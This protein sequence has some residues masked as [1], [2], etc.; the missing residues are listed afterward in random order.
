MCKSYSGNNYTLDLG[1]I[2]YGEPL[3]NFLFSLENAATASTADQLSGTFSVL[4]ADGFTVTG[5]SLPGPLNAGDSYSGL[6]VV[7]DYSKFGVDTETITFN[8]V[9]SNN[10]GFDTALAPITLTITDDIVAP[11]MVYSYAWGDVHII[12]YSGLTYNFQST[13]EFTLVKSLIPGDSFDIQ[14]RLQ[15]LSASASVSVITQ[16][17]VS[18]GSDT[19]T[20][21]LTRADFVYVDGAPTTV[22]MTDP[23]LHL[24]AGTLTELTPNVFQVNWN[25]GETMTVTDNGVWEN[26]ADGIPASEP[27]QVQGLQGEDDGPTADFQLSD[28]TVLPQPLSYATLY[29]PFA[30]SWRV[31]QGSS[32]FDYVNDQNADSFNVPGFPPNP[33]TLSDLPSSVVSAAAA[34]VAAAGITDPGLAQAAELDL[35]ATGNAD[36]AISAVQ[37]IATRLPTTTIV[38]PTAPPPALPAVSVEANPPGVVEAVNAVTPVTFE[39]YLTTTSTTDTV[40]DCTVV[41]GGTGYLG[42]AAFGGSLPSGTVTVPAGEVTANFTVDVPANALGTMPDAKLEVQISA[43]GG[44]TVFAPEATST[45]ANNTPEPGNLAIPELAEL[46]SVGTLTQNGSAYTLDLGTLTAGAAVPAVQLAILNAA[47]APGDSLTGKF[48]APLGSGFLVTGTALSSVL[49]PGDRYDG[50]KVSTQTTTPGT[51]TETLT[52]TPTDINDSGY[53]QALTP[54]TLKITDT[55]LP[56]ASAGLNTPGTIVFP[57]ARVG[58]VDREM[59]SV[60]NTAAAPAPNL[61]VTTQTG[62]SAIATGSISGLAAGQTDAT[63]IMAGLDTSQA[64]L[65]AGIVQLDPVSDAGGGSTEAL[66]AQQIDLYGGIYRLASASIPTINETVH[67]GDPG[68]V[69]LAVTNADPADGVSENLIAALSSASGDVSVGSAGPTGDIAAGA[70]SS[71]LTLTFS[72][73][74]AASLS[75]SAVVALT[76]DGGVG[77]GAGVVDGL[78]TISI[79]TQTVDANINVNNY[80]NPVIEQT[81][82]AG[83][84]SGSGTSYTLD[85]GNINQNASPVSADLEILNDVSGPADLLSGSFTVTSASVVGLSGFLSF[86]NIGAG[87]AYTAPVVTISP[88]TPGDFSETVTFTPVSSNASY[89]GALPVETLTIEGTVVAGTNGSPPVGGPAIAGTLAGQGTTDQAAI[90]PFSGVSITDTNA[91]PTET[92]TVTPSAPADGVLS[93]PNAGTDGGSVNGTTGVYTVTGTPSQVS[94]ALDGLVF[95]PTIHQV[96]PGQTVTTAFTIGVNDGTAT[97]S[98]SVT[99]VIATALNDP[100]VITIPQGG[101]SVDVSGAAAI[102]PGVTVSDPDVGQTETLTVSLD[103]PADGSFF[104][105]S[106]G[107]DGSSIDGTTGAFI[108]SGTPSAVTSILDALVLTPAGSPPETNATATISVSDGIASAMRSVALT[109]P[110]PQ[111]ACYVRGTRI[112]T[113]AGEVAVEALQIGDL[114]VTLSGAARPIKWI[115]QREYKGSEIAGRVDMLPV[116]IAAGA[117]ADLVPRRALSIS[118]EHA[119]FMEGVLIPA[120]ALVNGTTIAQAAAVERVEY[121]HVELDSHDVILAEGAPS[122]SFVDDASRVKFRNAAEYAALYPAEVPVPAVYCAPLMEHGAEVEAAR[123]RIAARAG[124]PATAAEGLCGYVDSVER[125]RIAGWACELARP[126]EGVELEVLADGAVIA[127]VVANRYR[128]D[129]AE[130]GL[131]R[132]WHGFEVS[133]PGGLSPLARHVIAV[134]RAGDGQELSNSPAV[135]APAAGLDDGLA[136]AVTHAVAE[137]GPGEEERVLSFLAARMEQV[138]QRRASLDLGAAAKRALVY[139][140]PVSEGWAASLAALRARSVKTDCS[141]SSAR[142][143]RSTA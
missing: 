1:Q 124:V 69:A 46:T 65:L 80:A 137:V 38:T 98:D 142:C 77:L 105:P 112:L 97:A 119:M 4:T 27:N 50:L 89:S 110:Q 33:V 99:T 129:L 87:S 93:D 58:A 116:T 73:K 47:M 12:T 82:G 115:G 56:P 107:T 20:F 113:I 23:V 136:E 135:L 24:A 49:L 3:P 54:I 16:T 92:V 104:D 63:D 126:D 57:N 51:H 143:G 37:Q 75:G 11:T 90:D 7:I 36:A 86:G 108:V 114:V 130:A 71:A 74:Q 94:A 29:G 17:A 55:V 117:L 123:R 26:V 125:D 84:L 91:N 35:I 45:I 133:I 95:T 96:T 109:L 2:Q 132:G 101:T 13:G 60:S 102:F 79:G 53:S 19:I 48:S 30:D 64:G 5:A 52:F 134:R 39:A 31:S 66:G 118:P 81:S 25:T 6:N 68:S 127:Q 44:D 131:G 10:T 128:G 43:P 83:T 88:T 140:Q 141:T 15:P 32:L 70:S 78:G 61:D 62:A 21:D 138:V 120:R 121:F 67:V 28:G 8:P 85:F 76:S 100:P 122:E 40:V 18:V 22:S 111:V 59:V 34:Q 139:S 42:A 72:T 103:N 14:L 41:D 106:A 9:D